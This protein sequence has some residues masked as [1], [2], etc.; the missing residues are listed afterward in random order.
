MGT[1]LI[2]LH[3]PPAAGKFT[4]ASRLAEITGSRI[5]HNH[6]TIDVAKSVFEFG[7]E[8]F[9]ALTDMLRLTTIEAAFA[10]EIPSM[11]ITSCYDHPADLPFF[12]KLERIAESFEGSIHPFYLSCSVS[13]LERRVEDDTR[14]EMGKVTT[15]SGLR[16]NLNRWNC[17]AVPREN[18]VTISTEGK[19]PE[20]CAD[21]ISAKLK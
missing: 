6:L 17:I 5:F 2:Y 18:C 15:I 1:Q 21:C 12:E 13:E 9:W 7:S 3:G 10:S 11:I 19:S 4:I 20:E 14:A 16:N 8:E